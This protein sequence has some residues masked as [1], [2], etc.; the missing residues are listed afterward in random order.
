VLVI[1]AAI[2]AVVYVALL[3]FGIAIPGWVVTVFWVLVVATVL[4]A[5]IKFL[6]RLG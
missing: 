2:V 4:V 5:A 1:I 3:Q 6:L